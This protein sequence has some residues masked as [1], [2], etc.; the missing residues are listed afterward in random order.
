VTILDMPPATP[1]ALP[2]TVLTRGIR[3]ALPRPLG[4]LVVDEELDFAKGTAYYTIVR[5]DRARG[6]FTI[7]PNHHGLTPVPTDAGVWYGRG[8]PEINQCDR[9]DRPVVNG[10]TLAGSTHFDHPERWRSMTDR[11]VD[12]RQAI[13][14]TSLSAAPYKTAERVGWIVIA[15]LSRY[16]DHPERRELLEAAAGYDAARRLAETRRQIADRMHAI[17]DL[18]AELAEHTGRERELQVL[19]ADHA[20]RTIAAAYFDGLAGF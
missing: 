11:D 3:L 14:R 5:A 4:E 18:T 16:T 8:L 12:T 20:K 7:R 9:T 10:I 17:A 15:L 6:S 13:S 19:A 1:T 2:Q